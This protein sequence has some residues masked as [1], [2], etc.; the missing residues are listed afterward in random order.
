MRECIGTYD[1]YLWIIPARIARISRDRGVI[2]DPHNL[3]PESSSPSP[4]HDGPGHIGASC[5][6]VDDADELSEGPALGESFQ[7]PERRPDATQPDIDGF[8]GL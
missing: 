2:V 1:G 8:K 6:P 4:T 3:D 5:S 7:V